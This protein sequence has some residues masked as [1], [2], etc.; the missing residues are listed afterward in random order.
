MSGDVAGWE[1]DFAEVFYDNVRRWLDRAPLR[2]VVD[3]HLGFPTDDPT[4]S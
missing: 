2:N 3:K 1:S 4:L